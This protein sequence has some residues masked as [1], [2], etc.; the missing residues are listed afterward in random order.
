M[1]KI[2]KTTF[3]TILVVLAI[4]IFFLFFN[5]FGSAGKQ[6]DTSAFTSDPSLYPSLGP[7]NS[8]NTVI[9]FSDFQCPYCGIDS[10]LPSW[11]SQ[12]T[13]QKDSGIAGKIENAANQGKLRFISVTM[14]FLGQ[15]SVYAAEA[16][17]CANDQGK[18]WEMHDAIFSNQVP[19]TQ[20]GTQF[21]KQELEGIGTNINGLNQTEFTNCLETDAHT[22]DVQKIS[23]EAG[24]VGIQGTPTFV[25]N[26]KILSDPTS[27]TSIL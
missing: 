22:F 5:P 27:L 14:S 24:N 19:P 1:V 21:T 6:I 20:E 10:G 12:Y 7:Q 25:L 9:E 26:G 16:A 4:I 18:F 13:N 11:S 3:W 23:S 15:G 8:Q 2:K 17:L